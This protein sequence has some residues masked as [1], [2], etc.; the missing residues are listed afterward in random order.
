MDPP[1]A[2]GRLSAFPV[3]IRLQIW[4]ELLCEPVVF[5]T[6]LWFLRSR[7][8]LS[9]NEDVKRIPF[10]VAIFQTS[11]ACGLEAME[12]FYSA[13]HFFSFCALPNIWDLEQ[14]GHAETR[15]DQF[16]KDFSTWMPLYPTKL[17]ARYIK[18]VRVS[19]SIP[20]RTYDSFGCLH[21]SSQYMP[22]MRKLRLPGRAR[23]ACVINVVFYSN[24]MYPKDV[25]V[26]GPSFFWGLQTLTAFKKVSIRSSCSCKYVH[27]ALNPSSPDPY[28]LNCWGAPLK[29][30]TIERIVEELQPTLGSATVRTEGK[31]EIVE[32]NPRTHLRNL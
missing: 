3:E 30:Y 31:M 16:I 27:L 11:K 24:N 14:M 7:D 13:E 17:A 15:V 8:A 18:N 32:F 9:H 2:F 26:L 22:L 6:P 1:S 21:M 23:G 10:D 19:I 4:Q 12:V 28:L 29:S 5:L 20:Q 25:Q